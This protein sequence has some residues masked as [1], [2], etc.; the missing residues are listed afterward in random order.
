MPVAYGRAAQ[1][2]RAKGDSRSYQSDLPA[3]IQQKRQQQLAN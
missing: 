3:G 2:P 1:Q